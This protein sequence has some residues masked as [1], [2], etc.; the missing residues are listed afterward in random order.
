MRNFGYSL[1]E[2]L[3]AKLT[4]KA[5]LH[6]AFQSVFTT[7]EGELVLEHICKA[8]KVFEATH[9]EGD[10][11]RSRLNEGRRELALEILR[12]VRRDHHAMVQMLDKQIKQ[13]EKDAYSN[14]A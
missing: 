4:R 7:P 13:N 1:V 8:G 6:A 5:K 3:R 11:E 9:K 10:V 12:F 14:N 2:N